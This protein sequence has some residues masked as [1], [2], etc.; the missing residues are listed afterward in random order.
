MET[1]KGVAVP[2]I[3]IELPGHG[4]AG[5]KFPVGISEPVKRL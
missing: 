5:S 4:K 2:V 3:R 1:W